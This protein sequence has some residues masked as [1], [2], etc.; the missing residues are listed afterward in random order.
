ASKVAGL[1]PASSLRFDGLRST[2]RRD[3]FGAE[4]V[5]VMAPNSQDEQASRPFSPMTSPVVTAVLR[6]EGDDLDTLLATRDVTLVAF[7]PYRDHRVE[8]RGQDIPLAANFTAGYGLWLANAGFARQS[9]RTLLGRQDG[10]DEPHIY[11]M[12]PYD[13]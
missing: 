9:I 4:L 1:V 3:G 5:A 13:P 6:F 8:I 7:N 2:Y 10:I 11:L 12:Q